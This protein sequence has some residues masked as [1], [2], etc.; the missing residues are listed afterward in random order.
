MV[1]AA[2]RFS[3]FS[4]RP[5]HRCDLSRRKISGAARPAPGAMAKEPGLGAAGGDLTGLIGAN[6]YPPASRAELLLARKRAKPDP[7]KTSIRPSMSAT[8]ARPAAPAARI[9]RTG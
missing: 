3:Q 6:R 4:D 5:C 1:R 7:W 8:P 2:P 9:R